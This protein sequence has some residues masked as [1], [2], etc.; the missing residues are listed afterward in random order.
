ML[1]VVGH[2]IVVKVQHREASQG[3]PSDKLASTAGGWTGMME[4]EECG[5]MQYLLTAQHHTTSTLLLL[6]ISLP[7]GERALSPVDHTE[8]WSW[9]CDT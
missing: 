2:L 4:G 6:A 5:S 9:D 8:Q 1:C 7:S 3:A